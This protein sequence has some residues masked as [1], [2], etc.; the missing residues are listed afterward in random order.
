MGQT[1]GI[2]SSHFSNV[3]RLVHLF[4]MVQLKEMTTCRKTGAVQSF[5]FLWGG[6]GGGRKGKE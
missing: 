6:G 5:F 3:D 4:N 2:S 1:A